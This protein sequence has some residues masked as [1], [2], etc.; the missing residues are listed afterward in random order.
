MNLH[1][2]YQG[3]RPTA[4]R[5]CRGYPS[6]FWNIKKIKTGDKPQRLRMANSALHE[7]TIHQ[8]KSIP[9]NRPAC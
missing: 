1:H 3:K 8:V 4:Q 6:K 7:L 9:E 5:A 2:G